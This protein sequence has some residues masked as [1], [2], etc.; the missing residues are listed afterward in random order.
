[1]RCIIVTK[2][3]FQEDPALILRIESIIVSSVSF[4][5][6]ELDTHGVSSLCNYLFI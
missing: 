5:L 1:M 3:T 4:I 2:I 6:R